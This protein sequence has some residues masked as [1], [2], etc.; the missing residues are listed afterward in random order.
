MNRTLSNVT[1]FLWQQV[2]QNIPKKKKKPVTVA[3]RFTNLGDVVVPQSHQS[4]LDLGLK[5]CFQPNLR[6]P[7]LLTLARKVAYKTDEKIRP[8]CLS[9]CVEAI[10]RSR[11]VQTQDLRPLV[12]F[13]VDNQQRV[14][15]ADKEGSC[16]IMPEGMYNKKR[17]R[18]STKEL[19]TG[20]DFDEKCEE[21]GSQS[22]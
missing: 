18:S 14:L 15:E 6:P 12:K 1:E 16:V 13:L 10:S 8:R 9:E 7:E 2:R 3:G 19:S 22:V 21:P 17:L 4:T 20:T 11:K 5:F